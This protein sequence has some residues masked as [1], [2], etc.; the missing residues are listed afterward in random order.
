MIGNRSKMGKVGPALVAVLIA[1][2]LPAVA[3]AEC[4]TFRNNTNGPIVVQATCVF[5]GA[6]RSDRPYVLNP[7]DSTPGISLPGN[8]I[9][10]VYDAR[11]PNVVLYRGAVAGG[12][13]DQAFSI[14][15]D[16]AGGVKFDRMAAPSSGP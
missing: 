12:P 4:L 14:A 15:P 11:H 1:A 10:T 16:G 5:K 6:L 13:A 3:S 2:A 7:G 9:I 8:K